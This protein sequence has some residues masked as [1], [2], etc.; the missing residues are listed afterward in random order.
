MLF[1]KALAGAILMFCSPFLSTYHYLAL[2]TTTVVISTISFY[3][4]AGQTA[5][6]E[7]RANDEKQ[8]VLKHSNEDK[9]SPKL[10]N[11]LND[12]FETAESKSSESTIHS[13]NGSA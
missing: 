13:Q 2:L 9:L 7:R 11:Y 6:M 10:E 12:G 5:K 3:V 8:I 1:L 4:V